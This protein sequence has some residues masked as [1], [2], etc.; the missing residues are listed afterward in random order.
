MTDVNSISNSTGEMPKSP[1]EMSNSKDGMSKSPDEM[2]NSKDEMSKSPD[3]M[4][5]SKDEMS[6]SLIGECLTCCEDEKLLIHEVCHEC[7]CN[8]YEVTGSWCL[9]TSDFECN[10]EYLM[11][12]ISFLYKTS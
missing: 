2:S 7:R 9:N 3:E 11:W 6:K 10:A 12:L 8:S 4:S 5:N 1:D